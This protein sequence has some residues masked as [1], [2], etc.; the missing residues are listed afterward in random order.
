MTSLRARLH[1]TPLRQ[2]AIAL[3]FASL[4]TFV[5]HAELF[6]ESTT[7]R[8]GKAAPVTL[9]LPP[10]YFRITMLRNEYHYL[11][12]SNAGCPDMVPIGST[13]EPGS[14][15]AGLVAA[16]ESNRRPF[17][18]SRIIASFVMFLLIGL[19]LSRYMGRDGMGRARWVRTQLAVFGVL[20]SV[21]VLCKALLL[22]TSLPFEV[23]PV[24]VL[25]LLVSMVIGRRLSFGVALASAFVVASLV[26]FDVRAMFIFIVAGV[27]SAIAGEPHRPRL[28]DLFIAS[29]R[30]SFI[31]LLAVVLTT[32]LFAGTLDIYEDLMD[33]VN[34]S[35]SIWLAGLFSG[36]GSGV[37]A[38]LLLPVF[39]MMVGQASRNQLVDL[40][41]LDHPLLRR[42]RERAPSTWEHSRAM[43][44]L[45][46]AAANAI[47]A[48]A[49]L[50]RVGA[51]FHDMGKVLRPD[52]FIENQGGANPHDGMEPIE[53]ARSIFNH[54]VE[55]VR[56]LRREGVPEDVV[57]FAYSHHGTS[58]LE[59]F[60]QKNL[61]AGNPDGL[62]EKD[63][64]Y[65]GHKPTTRETAILMIVDAMEAASRTVEEP[66]KRRL[67]SLL[68]RIVFG[69]MAQG[70]FD[71]SGLTMQD[72]RVV[73]DTIIDALVAMYHGR[74]K[75]QWQ[76]EEQKRETSESSGPVPV[77][78]TESSAEPPAEASGRTGD[79]T[80]AV[81]VMR[82]ITGAPIGRS[83]TNGENR[84]SGDGTPVPR[85]RDVTGSVT[86]APVRSAVPVVKETKR[87]LEVLDS[88]PT[89]VPEEERK[90]R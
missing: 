50:V 30:I 41:D 77:V 40:M 82:D 33:H 1:V 89:L 34:P 21:A 57:A 68:Q 49:M 84:P 27:F 58:V 88:T 71:E 62:S 66:D 90:P 32:L 48:N 86:I 23:L 42:L 72:L 67:E 51:Y 47:S 59:Y 37:L 65:P 87:V 64:C 10:G 73:M 3:V 29:I 75:Y 55:G 46:E 22:L 63:F 85:S 16:F 36:L 43:A 14:E 6:E 20:L 80:G 4:C 19:L 2:A 9:R 35:A 24:A 5:Q 31:I 7:V 15:C 39:G 83:A 12:A 69:K 52:F 8:A 17:E 25:P 79:I 74:I 70:Q 60:W 44:N 26:N 56:L 53:S 78:P 54:V 13:V 81:P 28:S 76:E 45:G 61:A 11:P 18:K 38:M